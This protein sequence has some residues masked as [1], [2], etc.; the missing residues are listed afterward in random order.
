MSQLWCRL[1]AEFANDPQIQ[2][3]AFED[4]RHF[5]MALCMKC[6]GLLDKP[7]A[8]PELRSRIIAVTLGLD[9]VAAAEANRRLR[10]S[11]LIDSDWQPLRW[12]KRQFKS[13]HD[14]ADRKRKQRERDSHNDV[15][16]Q[17]P[18]V[19]RSDT[20]TDTETEKTRAG[21]L[22]LHESLPREAWDEWIAHR[23]EKHWSMSPRAL[24]PQLKL[25]AKHATATQREIIE[26]S[27]NAGWQGLFEPKGQ[28]NSKP[29]KD[30]YANSI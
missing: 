19:T 8:S 2:I 30:P 17:S 3:L 21:A 29:R 1:Y 13:D 23:R 24:K 11:G 15:T 16:G 18:E 12:D 26:T 14:A 27:L 22:V 6:S 28:S 10:E 5:L 25:L 7:H 20:D 9:L 4:Q